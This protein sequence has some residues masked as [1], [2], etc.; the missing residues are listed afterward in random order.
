MSERAAHGS[1]T[2]HP[3][4]SLE[5]R[6]ERLEAINAKL[7]MALEDLLPWIERGTQRFSRE[8]ARALTQAQAAIREARGEQRS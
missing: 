5:S 7:L 4:H 3:Q 2:E 1:D 6:I 8:E